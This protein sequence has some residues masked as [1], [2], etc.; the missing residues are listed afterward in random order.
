MDKTLSDAL[1]RI[2]SESSRLN[3]VSDQLKE[4]VKEIEQFLNEISL[5]IHAWAVVE[6]ADH[7]TDPSKFLEF[8]RI[9][10]RFRFAVVTGAEATPEHEL[11][12]PWNDCSRVEKVETIQKLPELIAH[13][14][15][16]IQER[17]KSAEASLGTAQAVLQQLQSG[18]A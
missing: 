18:D 5:G 3:D 4:T 9:G 6:S 16:Q 14:G 1:S 10:S 8:R 12:K 11:V 13:L 17:N 15:K 2:R 7:P